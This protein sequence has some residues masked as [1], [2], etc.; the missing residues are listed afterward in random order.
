MYIVHSYINTE[1]NDKI[2]FILQWLASGCSMA[3]RAIALPLLSLVISTSL[4]T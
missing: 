1:N 3:A 2:A 4:K